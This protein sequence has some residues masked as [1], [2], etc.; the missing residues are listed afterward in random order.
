MNFVKG[1]DLEERKDRLLYR[2]HPQL[3]KQDSI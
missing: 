3:D 1:L 2:Y